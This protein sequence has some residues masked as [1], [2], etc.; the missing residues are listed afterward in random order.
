MFWK[1]TFSATRRPGRDCN[2]LPKG[3]DQNVLCTGHSAKIYFCSTDIRLIVTVHLLC[4]VLQLLALF[5]TVVF[6][7]TMGSSVQGTLP[8][9]HT[10]DLYVLHGSGNK[11]RLFP[12]TALTDW[13]V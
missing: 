2:A 3:M 12:Y 5:I 8:S 9:T 6:I 10:V 11:Q 7:C 13:F 1:F 4:T